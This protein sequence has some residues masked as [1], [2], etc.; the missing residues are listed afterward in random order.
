MTHTKNQEIS[1]FYLLQLKHNVQIKQKIIL[2]SIKLPLD[3][4]IT[5]FTIKNIDENKFNHNKRI[6]AQ[7]LLGVILDA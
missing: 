2:L 3:H 7:F 4:V 5:Y 1:R 6:R